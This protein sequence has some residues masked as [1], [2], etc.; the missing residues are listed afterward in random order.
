VQITYKV[1]AYPTERQHRTLASYLEHTRQLYNDCLQER[2]DCY[3]KTRRSIGRYDQQRSLT[4][5]RAALD[6]YRSY[7]R[8]MQCWAIDRV[9][10]AYRGMFTRHAK[11]EVLGRPRFRG[12]RFWSTIGWNSPIDF[13]MRPRGL[14]NRKSLGGT[15]RLRPHRDL[16][17]FDTC[18]MV[19]LSREGDRWFANLTYEVADPVAKPVPRRPVGIDLGLKTIVARSDGVL[20][21]VPRQSKTDVAKRRRLARAMDRRKKL[22]RGKKRS[23][24]WRKAREALRRHERR[25][26]NKRAA[27]LHVV[28]AR[29]VHHFDAVACEDL[30][31]AGLNQGGGGG[32]KGRGVRKSWRDRAPGKLV[33]QL[34]WKTQREGRPLACVDPRNTTIDCARCGAAVAKTLADRIHICSCGEVA[35]R[36]VNAARNVLARAG[37]GPGAVKLGVRSAA[38]AAS[39][40]GLARKDG[41]ARRTT[42]ERTSR[43]PPSTLRR[44]SIRE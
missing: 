36:D 24:G 35:D 16:P 19:T 21:D 27:K 22:V 6:C 9:D 18:T 38:F 37:W 40:A 42:V 8:R 3:A 33:E 15:L 10:S 26:A 7:P 39:G 2:V 20:I 4:E 30:N 31:I 11:G 5:A 32:A 28:S 44:A 23:R 14:Y 41:K 43:S 1:R 25:V 29:L 17:P 34:K 12:R 13:R